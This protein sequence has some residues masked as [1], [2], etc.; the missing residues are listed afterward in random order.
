MED[1]DVVLQLI[2]Y[3]LYL[4]RYL[5]QGSFPKKELWEGRV[6]AP[7]A[8]GEDRGAEGI[9]GEWTGGPNSPPPLCGQLTRCLS[10]VA[11]LIVQTD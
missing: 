5:N 1:F 6:R 11:E 8:P 9:E 7:K 2:A 3:R 4:C 10:A